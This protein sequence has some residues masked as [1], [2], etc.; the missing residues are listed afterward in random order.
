ML[1]RFIKGGNLSVNATGTTSRLATNNSICDQHAIHV[2][3]DAP[4][5]QLHNIQLPN[6]MTEL[7]KYGSH[8]RQTAF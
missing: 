3:E 5:L 4:K 6:D 1:Y 8:G 7:R 2:S